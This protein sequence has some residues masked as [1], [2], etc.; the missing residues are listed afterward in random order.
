MT[1]GNSKPRGYELAVAALQS[2]LWNGTQ[3]KAKFPE[4]PL[5]HLGDIHV[6][7][8]VDVEDVTPSR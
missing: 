4:H 5:A 1:E 6:R 2:H 3:E 7:V 8:D